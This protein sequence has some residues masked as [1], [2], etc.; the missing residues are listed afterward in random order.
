[1]RNVCRGIFMLATLAALPAAGATEL[2]RAR[3]FFA[4]YCHDCHSGP[5]AEAGLDLASLPAD[6]SAPEPLRRFTR[7]YDRVIAGEM[8]PK[9][10]EQP[11]K[12]DRDD[13]LRALDAALLAA[14]RA[15][16][17]DAGRIRMRRMTRSEY[18]NTLRDLLALPRLEIKDLLPPDARIAGFDKV[19]GA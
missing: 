12:A 19:A 7:V 5:D 15:A 10:S 6:L 3:G 14:D 4:R 18:E 9:D 2:A 16:T 17:A 8:P 11:S 13:V 1:M